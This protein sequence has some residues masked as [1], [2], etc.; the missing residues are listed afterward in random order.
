V[1]QFAETVTG[2]IADSWLGACA[3]LAADGGRVEEQLAL[4]EA[5]LDEAHE[6]RLTAPVTRTWMAEAPTVVVG[7]SSR[8]DDEVDRAVCAK[9]GIRVIR[10]PSGGLTV[11][12]GPGCVMWTVVAPLA[13][14]SPAI[15]RIHAAMLEPLCAALQGVGRPVVRRGSSDLAIA[16]ADGDRKVSGNA[17][18]LRRGGVLYHGTLLDSFDLTL[19]GRILRHP[20]REPEYRCG[21]GHGAFLANLGLGREAIDATVRRAFRADAVATTWPAE[22]VEALVRERY[23]CPEWT[24]RLV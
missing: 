11:V 2:A 22:R 4:D 5:L 17:L 1:R 23:D 14:S 10:R 7:S 12:L 13:G 20:P 15:E 21:R 3:W 24:E 8:I 19:V 9:L 18:R 16:T 6:G